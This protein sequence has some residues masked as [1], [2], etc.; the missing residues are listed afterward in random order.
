MKKIF[1]VLLSVSIF[2]AACKKENA[3]VAQHNDTNNGQERSS[4]IVTYFYKGS[5]ID[6]TDVDWDSETLSIVCGFNSSLTD[7]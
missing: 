7:V 2:F 6:S 5:I 1:L 3:P 4:G